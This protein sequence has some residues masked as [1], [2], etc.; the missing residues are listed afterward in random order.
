MTR[1]AGRR[2]APAGPQVRAKSS[3][4]GG[5]I[6]DIGEAIQGHAERFGYGVVREYVGHGIGREFHEAPQ[7][8]HYRAKGAN[9]RLR[10]GM[11]FTIEPMINLGTHETVLDPADGW[12][13]RT[14]DG[15]LSAQFEHTILVTDTGHEILTQWKNGA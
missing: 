10:A 6:R 3:R 1:P 7:V 5:R 15:R 14:R 9:P 12:T 4:P 8:P 11:T 13:V 2:G